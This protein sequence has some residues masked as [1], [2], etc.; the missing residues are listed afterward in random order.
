M[1]LPPLHWDFCIECNGPLT[2]QEI[3]DDN[4][5]CESCMNHDSE[6]LTCHRTWNSIETPTPAARCP[7][8][9]DHDMEE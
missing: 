9:W 8:E 3:A 5:F 6:C 1:R 4:T 7:Y 2:E